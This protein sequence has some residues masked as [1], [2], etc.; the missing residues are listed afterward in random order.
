VAYKCAGW[1]VPPAIELDVRH[2]DVGDIVRMRD[3]PHLEGCS[4]AAK[5]RLLADGTAGVLAALCPSGG[6]LS[7]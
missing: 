3:L 7:V 1:A 5:V 4:L 6:L 2:M